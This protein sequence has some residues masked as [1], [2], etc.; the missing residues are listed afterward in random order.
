[1]QAKLIPEEIQLLRQ[2][3]ERDRQVLGGMPRPPAGDGL[4]ALG[5]VKVY[6]LNSQDLQFSITPAGRAALAAIDAGT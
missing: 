6:S 3:N 4:Q 1:M 2:L 5:Y